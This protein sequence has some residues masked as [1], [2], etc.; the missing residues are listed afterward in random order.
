LDL[1]RFKILRLEGTFKVKPTSWARGLSVTADGS[2]VV[3][4]A[5]SVAVRLLAD[6][7]G[8]TQGLSAALSRRS[9][10]PVH[11]RGQVWVDVATMLTA[12]GEAISDIDSLRHHDGL[13]GPVAS[14]P[15]VWRTL[16][17]VTPAA[18][19]RV[20]KA[21]A[22]I[23]AHVWGLLPAL[24]ASQAAGVELGDVV[25]LDV[26][27]TLVTAHSE[28]EQARATFKAGFGFHPLGV[29]CDNTQELLA[30]TLRPGNAGSVRHEVARDEWTHDWRFD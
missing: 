18:L 19:K 11:D 26:D 28:K 6:R 5:G 27:A 24:P 30:V 15:T 22:M 20:E 10:S 16:N 9:F 14:P 7:V 23:R 1:R 13:L 4:L 29:W 3:P 25:V 8:F 21:R 12:G 17:E 2:G